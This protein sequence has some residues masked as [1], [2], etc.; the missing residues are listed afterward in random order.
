MIAAHGHQTTGFPLMTA[1]GTDSGQRRTCAV[2]LIDRRTGAAHRING[3]PLIL[4]TRQPDLA[5]AALLEGR[6]ATL[7]EARVEPLDPEARK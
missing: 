5:V 7:W 4:F 6:D 3:H 1:M 2:H